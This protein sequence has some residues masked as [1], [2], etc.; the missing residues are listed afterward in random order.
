[1]RIL[2]VEDHPK[3]RANIIEFAKLQSITADGAFNGEE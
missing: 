2:I 3:I 1:M